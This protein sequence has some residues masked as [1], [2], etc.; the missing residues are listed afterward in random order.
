[1][2]MKRITLVLS[3]LFVMLLAGAQDK[4]S[5]STHI[6]LMERDGLINLDA[7]SDS[8]MRGNPAMQRLSLIHI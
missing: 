8:M 3:L 4:L 7:R 1:M 5:P 6:F 2:R